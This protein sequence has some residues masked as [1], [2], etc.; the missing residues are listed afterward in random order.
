MPARFSAP[1]PTLNAPPYPPLSSD[2]GSTFAG[3]LFGGYFTSP[4]LSSDF[5]SNDIPVCDDP[6][7]EEYN[8][9]VKIN[10]TLQ[11]VAE[12]LLQ[13]PQGGSADGTTDIML[14]MGGD[15]Q[16]EN[17]PS[18]YLNTDALIHY[19][20]LDGRVR[21]FYSTPSLYADA[22]LEAGRS[23]T[24]KTAD[25]MPYAIFPH[26]YLTGFYSSRPGLKGY[27]RETSSVFA[28]ARQLQAFAGGA[29]DMGRGN[30]LYRLERALGVA[31]HH[32]A[33]TGTSRQDVAYD[34]AR[35]LA[36]GRED[37]E[38]LLSAALSRLVG[39]PGAG[40]PFEACDLSNTT[41]CPALEAGRPVVLLLYNQQAQARALNLRLPVGLPPGVAS[42]ALSDAAGAPLPAQRLPLS[43]VDVALRTRVQRVYP[44]PCD[45]LAG[46][47]TNPAGNAFPWSGSGGAAK[48]FELRAGAGAGAF[49]AHSS[50]PDAT[51]WVSAAGQL[52]AD[53]SSAVLIFN[54][55]A[56]GAPVTV[57]SA[58]SSACDT[59]FM[60]G[61]LRWRLVESAA[62]PPVT[63]D[64]EWLAFAVAELPPAGY[65]VVFL[66]PVASAG[67]APHTHASRLRRLEPAPGAPPQVLS[68]GLI[69]LTFDGD[70]H[71]LSQY[72]EAGGLSLPLRAQLGWYNASRGTLADAGGISGAYIFRPNSSTLWP[73]E[74]SSP[75]SLELLE[76][77]ILSEAR[78][79]YQGQPAPGT[80]AP[81]ASSVTRLWAGARAVQVEY[82][83]GPI[84]TAADGWGKEVVARYDTPLASGGVWWTDSNGR[85]SV[86]RARDARPDY[87]LT[88]QEEVAGNYYPVSGFIFLEDAASGATLSVV[89][90]RAQGGASLADGSLE[91][92]LHR[93][94]VLDDD[95]G[96]N[97]AL[98]EPGLSQGDAGLVIRTTHTLALAASG[99]EGA[100]RRRAA[101]AEALWRPLLRFAP[102]D[103]PPSAWAAAHNPRFAGLPD[104][105]PLSLHLLTAQP[106]G[107]GAL[108]LRLAH[109]FEAGEGGEAATPASAALG[110]L[111]APA[112]LTLGACVEMTI[113][114]NQPLASAPSVTYATTGGGAI[115]LPIVPDPPAGEEQTVTLQ[116]LQIRTF[117]CAA[118]FH[119]GPPIVLPARVVT[120]RGRREGRG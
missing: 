11:L 72:E 104:A 7:L 78:S 40:V 60:E 75:P 91:L 66:E 54:L 94:L 31:Q 34:Y 107:P 55:T 48:L 68:N 22:K 77:P 50:D 29:A 25:F 5:Y 14:V 15:F 56:G 92:M 24:K 82:T 85:D 46:A 41:I 97:E 84:P 79:A 36:A 9:D 52:S 45:H 26:G 118:T 35:R 114:G 4:G 115:T 23:Y 101:L 108:L 99:V 19:L 62:P 39:G 109:S 59:F 76:G 63:P 33:I 51:G 38:V 17:S 116:A 112:L 69:R 105:L 93:R 111:F 95:L 3:I 30:P 73:V 43:A 37:A 106:L 12:A 6:F 89:V 74:G 83:I 81:W 57:H 110:R 67:D 96:V 16:H 28:A 42:W 86:R 117:E 32:D 90:D 80:A 53:N 64:M 1:V 87:N 100:L 2:A 44:Q 103:A 27:I 13:V 120:R 65:T 98:T 18:W 113:S 58:V 8:V 70:S 10:Q 71:E 102:L 21:A 61:G 47:W 119:N 49:T 20:N 88:V